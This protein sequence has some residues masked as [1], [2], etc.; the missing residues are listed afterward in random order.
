MGCMYSLI[1]HQLGLSVF[2]LV[3]VLKCNR[4]GGVTFK[5]NVERLD[6]VLSVVREIMN[7]I[8]PVYYISSTFGD[9]VSS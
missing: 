8:R 1:V 2:D 9:R 6:F 4:G 3:S 5:L 7:E